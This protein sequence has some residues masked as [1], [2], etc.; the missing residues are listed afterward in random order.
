M[1]LLE[2]YE[3]EMILLFKINKDN[4][5]VGNTEILLSD[6]ANHSRNFN[7]FHEMFNI[8][9]M[10]KTQIREGDFQHMHDLFR[11]IENIYMCK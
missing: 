5:K 3:R 6:I 2:N 11:R 8:I 7:L 1:S 4:F 10:N 9:I